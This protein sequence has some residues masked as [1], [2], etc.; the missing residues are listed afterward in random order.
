MLRVSLPARRV[1]VLLACLLLTMRPDR[2]GG[3]GTLRA[4]VQAADNT[5]GASTITL[6]A[7]VYKLTIPSTAA[8]DPSNGDRDI[9]QTASVTLTGAGPGK[10]TIDAGQVDRAF[11]VQSGASMSLSGV[12]IQNGST[13]SGASST[14]PGDGGAIYSAG[15][16]S[17]TGDVVLSGNVASGLGGGI[18]SGSAAGSTLSVKGATFSKD[19]SSSVGGAIFAGSPALTTITGSTFTGDTSSSPGGAVYAPGTGGL[20]IDSSVFTSNTGFGWRRAQRLGQHADEAGLRPLRRQQRQR[21][22]AGPGL[23]SLR[24]G[25]HA[26]G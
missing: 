6:P 17:L 16:L 7:G 8:D 15:A 20:T 5:G 21:E 9:N 3:S 18:D 22:R 19:N 1:P 11:A 25:L 14:S 12:T 23:E 4:A 13:S 26:G 24:G 10:T 2:D